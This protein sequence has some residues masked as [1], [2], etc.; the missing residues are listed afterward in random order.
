MARRR[1]R[2][3]DAAMSDL[4]HYYGIPMW[5]T[6]GSDAHAFDA[7]AAME[8]TFAIYSGALSGSNLIHDVGFMGQGLI[9]H[10]AMLLMCN[11][12]ISYV[13]RLMRGFELTPETL[14]LDVDPQRG[15]GRQLHGR[16]AHGE[17]LPQGTVA[18]AVHE[19]RRSG[20]MGGE[21]RVRSYEELVERKAAGAAGDASA[22]AAAGQRATEDQRHR[23]PGSRGAGNDAFQGLAQRSALPDGLG[24]T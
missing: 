17:I 1:L 24:Q 2:L 11:E 18:A 16:S 19:S 7:Q 10:P 6:T 3:A 20:H 23:R 21:G 15:A 9:S 8:H 4:Y 12:I 13:K 14:G 5:A 22:G